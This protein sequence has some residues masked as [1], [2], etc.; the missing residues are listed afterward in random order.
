APRGPVLLATGHRDSSGLLWDVS[1]RLTANA[2]LDGAEGP[3]AALLGDDAERA[4][5]A[6]RA[7]AAA[8]DTGVAAIRE[9]L[10]P[11]SGA[12]LG[13]AALARLVGQLEADNFAARRRAFAALAEEGPAAEP[14][15]KKAL[16]GKPSAELR[17]RARELLARLGRPGASGEPLRGLRALEVLE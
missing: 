4:F 9:R 6:Q 11:A 8:G 12:P 2:R 5:E 15:L 10:R 7:L 17:R 1:G 16:A 14:H 13:A 3:W